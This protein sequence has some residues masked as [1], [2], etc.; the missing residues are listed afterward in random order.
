[1][2]GPF[3]PSLTPPSPSTVA[4]EVQGK[5]KS[6]Y[7]VPPKSST[8]PSNPKVLPGL[9]RLQAQR[10]CLSLA[11]QTSPCPRHKPSTQPPAFA[12]A[13]PFSWGTVPSMSPGLLPREATLKQ[14]IFKVLLPWHILFYSMPPLLRHNRIHLFTVSFRCPALG[15]GSTLPS[16][17]RSE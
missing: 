4:R 9:A 3:V 2:D 16:L 6:D 5:S 12:H 10:C 17:C 14:P 1:M 11:A 13:V 15:E 8:V 7:V